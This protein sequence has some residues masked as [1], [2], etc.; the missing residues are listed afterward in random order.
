MTNNTANF[1]LPYPSS[2]DEPCDF[3]QQ[4]CDFTAAIDGVFATFQ[5]AIDRTIPVIPMA[6]MQQTAALS[7]NNNANIAFDT[8]LADT[9]GMTDIDVDPFHIIIRRPGRYTIA[10]ALDKPTVGAPFVTAF[11]SVFATPNGDAQ[12]M[13]FDRGAGVQYFFNAYLPVQTY[14]AGDKIGLTYNMGGTGA[15]TITESWL[16][17]M[18]HSDTEV[19]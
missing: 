12:V 9:A 19:P 8:V 14:A 6:I 4:W 2:F 15:F 3:A 17:V 18:W 7:V 5:S 11:T 13:L 10:A 1:N 16:A